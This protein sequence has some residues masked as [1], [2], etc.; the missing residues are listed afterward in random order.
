[1]PKKTGL[2]ETKTVSSDTA[3]LAACVI[4]GTRYGAITYKQAEAYFKEETIPI[5]G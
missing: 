1:M 2:V 4:I 3:A 5:P